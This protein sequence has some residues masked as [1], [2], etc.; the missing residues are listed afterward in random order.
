MT[1]PTR[2]LITEATQIQGERS[3]GFSTRARA[4]R[5]AFAALSVFCVH[6][7]VGAGAVLVF[8]VGGAAANIFGF[9]CAWSIGALTGLQGPPSHGEQATEA[10]IV[11]LSRSVVTL[12]F[13]T[14]G[15]ML[16]MSLALIPVDWAGP[17]FGAVLV[18]GYDV[19]AR[20][21]R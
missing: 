10:L 17:I 11:H 18:L 4:R 21:I 13:S 8:Q 12:L 19:V 6:A 1:R 9:A 3:M 7:A 2:A 20:A 5:A 14:L 15:L 16:A